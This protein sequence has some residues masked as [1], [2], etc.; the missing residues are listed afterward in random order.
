MPKKPETSRTIAPEDLAP[1]Q[2][3]AVSRVTYELISDEEVERP[4]SHDL[5]PRRI[6]LIP[7]DAGEPLKVISVS[8]PFVMVRSAKGAHDTLDLR[9]IELMQ[10]G[11]TYGRASYERMRKDHK[12]R[13]PNKSKRRSPNP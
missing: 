3:V 2:F 1:G 12:E 6:R 8:V 5:T 4:F 7:C 9:R 11:T 10:L 13:K